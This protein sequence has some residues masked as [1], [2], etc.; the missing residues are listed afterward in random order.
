MNFKRLFLSRK[1]QKRIFSWIIISFVTVLMVFS[2]FAYSNIERIVVRKVYET[3]MDILSQVKFNVQLMDDAIK[4]LCRELFINAD[5]SQLMYSDNIDT[6]ETLLKMKNVELIII[7]NPFVDSVY[8]YNGNTGTFYSPGKSIITD[9]ELFSDIVSGEKSI[10]LLKPLVLKKNIMSGLYG[11][12]GRTLTY[13]MYQYTDKDN[14]P[15]GALIINIKTSWL[16]SNLEQ[17]SKSGK[18]A[19]KIFVFNE[20]G[21]YIDDAAANGEPPDYMKKLFTDYKQGSLNA[22]NSKGYIEREINGNK[23][24]I[25][26]LRVESAGLVLIRTQPYDDVFGL[27]TV[28]RVA[29]L[30]ITLIFLFIVFAVSII[31]SK[32]I[33]K[34]LGSFISKIG[35]VRDTELNGIDETDE[36]YYLEQAYKLS[37]DKLKKYENDYTSVRNKLKE[38]YLKKLLLNSSA[39]DSN[40]TIK[41]FAENNI[42]FRVNEGFSVCILKIDRYGEFLKNHDTN[43]RALIKFAI[44]NIA[45]EVISSRYAAEGVDMDDDRVVL[46]INA[47]VKSEDEELFF[48]CFEELIKQVQEH[49]LNYFNISFSA[50]FSECGKSLNELT[51]LYGKAQDYS[52]YRLVYGEMSV[53]SPLAAV[54]NKQNK[55]TFDY[56]RM[57]TESIK[58]E[59]AE[60]VENV[61]QKLLGETLKFEYK[62]IIVSL[63]SIIETIEKIVSDINSVSLEPID[64]DFALMK[65]YIFE[66]ETLNEFFGMVSVQ[67]KKLCEKREKSMV[68]VK[69]MMIYENVK[70][71]IDNEFH[72]SS[73]CL[74]SIASKLKIS[75]GYLGKIFKDC[76]RMSVNEYINE[77]RLNKASEWLRKSDLS[78]REILLKVGIENETYF[79]I[80]FKKRFGVT[81]KEYSLNNQIAMKP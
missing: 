54:M 66:T 14:I 3:N 5:V 17:I 19:G 24:I 70:A 51:E 33:Y 71:I 1:Y 12:S 32:V 72:N 56:E 38:F 8:I 40:D 59:S 43:D 28:M 11:R 18:D 63:L 76:C 46:I 47:N 16:L 79:Y 36:M 2:V 21:S 39:S 61:L 77:I 27:F 30:I 52:N 73:L 50:A 65:K 49:I 45:C 22:E 29:L 81:P 35:S 13:F 55:Y 7:A 20:E 23:S 9:K 69:H 78:I 31:V 67:L 10:P 60:R 48:E 68:N 41:W 25:S 53:I 44:I 64:V 4:N 15:S 62:S 74:A 37:S 57:L 6:L 42:S 80:L 75:S 58:S 34:P 26:F